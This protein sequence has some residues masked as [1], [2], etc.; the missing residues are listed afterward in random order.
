MRERKHKNTTFSQ[1]AKTEKKENSKNTP[2][3][4]NLDSRSVL[5]LSLSL[6]LFSSIG[7]HS[8]FSDQT[9]LQF[10]SHIA[11]DRNLHSRAVYVQ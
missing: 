8:F 10:P 9:A 6:S 11:R 5:S 2:A 4:G 1:T 7:A 3:H